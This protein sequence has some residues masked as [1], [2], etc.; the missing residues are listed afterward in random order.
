MAVDIELVLAPVDNSDRA[1]R[2]AEYAVAVADRYRANLHLLHVIDER[3]ARG[4]QTGDV[5]AAAVAD[6]HRAFTAAVRHQLADA[7]GIGDFSHSS[8]AGFSVSS[9]SRMPGSV[10]LDTAEELGAD[11]IVLPRETPSESPEETLGKAALYVLEY[12][13]QPV[14][15]V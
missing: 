2:A 7:D 11:I 9:L 8:A 3:I 12:A 1:E 10:V 5:D 6:E 4:I 13:S 15:S 14:L